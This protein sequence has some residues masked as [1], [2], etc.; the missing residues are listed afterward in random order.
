MLYVKVFE[1]VAGLTAFVCATV[2]DAQSIPFSGTITGV[3]SGS[4]DSSCAPATSR[5]ILNP[6]SS[7]GSS[8]LGDFTYGHNWC[9]YGPS[10]PIAGTFDLFFGTDNV[11]GT[12]AGLASP[13]GTTGLTNLN[14]AYTILSGTGAYSGATGTFG[15]IATA[16]IRGRSPT[17]PLFTLNF[18]GNINAPALPEPATWALMLLGFA[19]IGLSLRVKRARLAAV[20]SSR[21]RA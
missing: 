6:S 2:A 15:G 17:A 10:G 16:D 9:F 1:A 19:G 13:S 5:G 11:H 12:L 20:N 7:S 3:G 18:T 14:L 21:L 4:L 8:T